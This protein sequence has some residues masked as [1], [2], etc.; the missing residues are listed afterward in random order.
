VVRWKKEDLARIAGFDLATLHWIMEDK[1]RLTVATDI[2][3]HPTIWHFYDSDFDKVD[4]DN[5]P[6]VIGNLDIGWPQ[7]IIENL[8]Q[9][10][11]ALAPYRK[12]EVANVS[13][14]SDGGVAWECPVHGSMAIYPAKFGKGMQCSR[15]EAV[16]PGGSIPSWAIP[17][18]K[19]VNGNKR[20]YCS[21]REIPSA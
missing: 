8:L 5:I 9:K 20:V 16:E 19:D 7:F 13:T 18:V 17:K 2:S 6:D 10:H 4:E 3:G 11:G 12:R 1:L 15:W 21:H 14:P